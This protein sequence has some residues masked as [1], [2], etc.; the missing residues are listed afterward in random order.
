MTILAC[1]SLKLFISLTLI[2]IQIK[3]QGYYLSSKFLFYFEIISLRK[4]FY[5]LSPTDLQL[6]NTPVNNFFA[7]SH[8]EMPHVQTYAKI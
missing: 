4:M 3:K 2:M 6:Q 7:A 8:M 5:L 1:Y